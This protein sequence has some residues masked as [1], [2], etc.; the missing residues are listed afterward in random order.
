[1]VSSSQH[2]VKAYAD[3]AA[4]IS[5]SL[6]SHIS[7]LRQ[8]DQKAQELD[9]SFKPSKCVSYLLDGHSH[10]KEGIQRSGAFT[11][12]ITEGSTKFLGK[13]LDVSL[14]ATEAT[15]KKKISD[16]LS[17]LLS[18]IDALPIRGEFKLCLY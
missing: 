9:L 4:L 3:D 6:E 5:D 14:S 11:K 2:S 1:M 18:T 16:K 7:V 12:S 8:D 15:A 13:S 10:R 17:I